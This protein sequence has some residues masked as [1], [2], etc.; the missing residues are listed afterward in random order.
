[1]IE[2][3][4]VAFAELM[5]AALP[6]YRMECS[7]ATKKLWWNL[8][9]PYQIEVVAQAFAEHLRANGDTITPNHIIKQVERI[10]PDGRLGVEEAWAMMARDESETVVV[11]EE[12]MEA[13]RFAQPLLNEGDRIGARMAF[14]EAYLLIVDNNRRTGVAPKW[15]PSIGTDKE[16]RE[17]AIS[18]AVRLGRLPT[19]HAIGLMAPD[20]V[21]EML[22][23][24]GESTLALQY[25]KPS[26][27]DVAEK[28]A[29]AKAALIRKMVTK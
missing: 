11:T 22:E 8:L 18:E 9:S 28:I 29:A 5:D 21:S 4:V 15:F 26:S 27:D 23:M 1:M 24:A 16:S 10:C 20:K 12:M 17:K 14:K 6:V 19:S 13:M 3:D 7:T 2:R 25:K